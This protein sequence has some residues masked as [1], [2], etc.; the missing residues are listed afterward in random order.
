MIA[1]NEELALLEK[2]KRKLCLQ[3]WRIKLLTHLHPEEMMVRNTTGCTEWSEAIKTARI[4][5]INPACYGDR[6]VPFNFEKTLVHELLHLK[7]SFWCQNEDDV[8]CPHCGEVINTV[9]IASTDSG[10]RAWYEFL[11]NIGYCVPYGKRTEEK[12]WNCLDMV[13]DNEQAKQ[14]ADYAVKKEV[15]N[16]D[17][18]ESVVA[19]ALMHENKVVIN[20]NW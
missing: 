16:W 19:T 9:D 2:W 13:L 14:L 4:E 6:I 10:G 20:A 15:Y 3:E 18:V 17:G 11:E 12:D 7:F 8:G 5:I 1:T